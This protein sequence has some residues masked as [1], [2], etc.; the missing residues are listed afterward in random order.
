VN[1]INYATYPNKNILSENFIF[2]NKNKI[3]SAEF[4]FNPLTVSSVGGSKL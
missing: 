2:N 1:N 3:K 4:Y